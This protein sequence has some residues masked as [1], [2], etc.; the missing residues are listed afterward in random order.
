M[1][2]FFAPRPLAARGAR[3]LLLPLLWRAALVAGVGCCF[4][5]R[6]D[7][8]QVDEHVPFRDADSTPCRDNIDEMLA[9]KEEYAPG[10]DV[11][12][13]CVYTLAGGNGAHILFDAVWQLREV[14][15]SR[16]CSLQVE[17]CSFSKK[18]H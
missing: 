5:P 17:Q 4:V 12:P 10:P 6:H 8:V 18:P 13:S 15:A 2:A 7:F 11:L 1:L 9:T 16:T 3:L 14:A